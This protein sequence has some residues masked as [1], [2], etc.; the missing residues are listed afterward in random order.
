MKILGGVLGGTSAVLI[1]VLLL[2]YRN[3][4]DNSRSWKVCSGKWTSKTFMGITTNKHL[5][6]RS[7]ED[8]RIHNLNTLFGAC[9]DPPHVC[10]VTEYWTRGSLKACLAA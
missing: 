8:I 7:I 10:I 4:G 5:A 1:L 3:T 9:T 6:T 2:V